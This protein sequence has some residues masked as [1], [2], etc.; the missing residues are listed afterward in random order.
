MRLLFFIIILAHYFA[1]FQSSAFVDFEK[2]LFSHS[3]RFYLKQP[4]ENTTFNLHVVKSDMYFWRVNIL[5]SSSSNT[6]Y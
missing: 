1:L 2:S 4:S 5:S 6:K 3:R